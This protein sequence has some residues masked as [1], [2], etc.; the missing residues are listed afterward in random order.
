M[1]NPALPR[2][3]ARRRSE[4]ERQRR[5]ARRRIRTR[6]VCRIR[7]RSSI[8]SRGSVACVKTLR[9]RRLAAAKMTKIDAYRTL[10]FMLKES[11][12]T[13]AAAQ[14]ALDLFERSAG[15][16]DEDARPAEAAL[17]EGHQ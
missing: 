3:R 4:V 9:V 15:R 17:P 13:L 12:V 10:D 7:L 6:S 5:A 1:P 8:L 14:A 2:V 11:Y 16:D